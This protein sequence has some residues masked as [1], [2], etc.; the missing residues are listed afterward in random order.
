[1]FVGNPSGGKLL[2]PL[3]SVVGYEG[4]VMTRLR[5]RFPGMIA[6]PGLI[7]TLAAGLAHAQTGDPLA[8]EGYAEPPREIRDAVLAPWHQNVSVG[9]L[10][11]DRQRFIIQEREGMPPISLLA[12]PHV[13]L[14]GVPVDLN[15]YRH[16][17]FTIR[18]AG[19]FRIHQLADGKQIS[20]TAPG[21]AGVSDPTWSPDGSRIAF[22]GHY[23]EGTYLYVADAQT[24]RTK[25]VSARPVLA[26]LS[27]NFE[28]VQGGKA[29]VAVL[30]PEGAGTR[31]ALGDAPNGPLVRVTDA[32]PKR[33]RTHASLLQ[34]PHDQD[35]L[36]YFSTGQ[37][38]VVDV[39]RGRVQ[40]IGKPAMVS[41][42]SSSPD[43]RFFRVTVKERPFSYLVP[44]GSFPERE[45]IWDA[46]GEQKAQIAS[47]GLRLGIVSDPAPVDAW[48][49]FGHLRPSADRWPTDTPTEQDA[50]DAAR[51]PEVQAQE[52]R[53]AQ[54]AAP[55]RSLSWRPDGAGLSFLQLE[56]ARQGSDSRRKDRV[57]LWKGPYGENDVEVVYE[58]EEG[59][60]NLRYSED[61]KTLFINQA[62]GTNRERI[63]MVRLSEPA[64]PVTLIEWST[65]DTLN[66]TGDLVTKPSDVIGS[67]VRMSSDGRYVYLSGTRAF[68]DPEKD[69]PR[70]FLDRLAIG[71]GKPERIFESSED[72]FETATMLDD[73]AQTLLV[74]RQSPTA[75][76]NAFLMDRS[77]KTEVQITQNQ[78]FIPDLTQARKESL[79]VTR[80]DGI[81]FRVRVTLPPTFHNNAR[82]PALFWFYP[83]EYTDQAA[84]NRTLRSHNKNLFTGVGPTSK[85]IFLRHGYVLVEPDCP[86]IGP[87][88]RKNDG[89][90]PQLRNNL[91]AVIDALDRAGY[92]DRDRLALGGHS[93]G[94]FSTANAM[95]HTPFFRAGIAGAGNYNR[96]LTPFGFQSET[97]Q[98]WES[99]EVYLGMSPMLHL[100]QLTGALLLYHG[101]Q[102]QNMGT[103]PTN[104]ERLYQALEGLG[105]PASLYMYPYED[106]GQVARETVLDMWARWI[107]WMEQYVKNPKQAESKPAERDGD[108][109]GR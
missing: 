75:I 27:T 71:S 35:L 78:D 28:W 91:Y 80:P 32:K 38:A 54:A 90:I 82:M 57:M 88:D 49:E 2:L 93:Y 44:I 12:R 11:R 55:R 74:N 95:V 41:S 15:A 107:A 69:A 83:R 89:Y 3:Q 85:T 36:E 106:H 73:D 18:S 72:R 24:G 34:S 97:R 52:P 16:R 29:L 92:I 79:M 76:G 10:S 58:S 66:P 13:I 42:F 59:I 105:K 33:L 104:S 8:G 22:F 103:S 65:T 62:A 68:R 77:R 43:G 50:Q 26:T 109:G 25:R 19:G 60:R 20:I 87:A 63:I 37:L 100:E 86:I 56:P 102:D 67:V 21:N 17:R 96:L 39:E 98:L 99:R 61:C 14:A 40:T 5:S 53:S 70:P 31:P 30:V 23:P 45:V 81:R 46:N 47:R 1:M 101:A 9:N 4:G 84:Y 94:A 6:C 51:T 64:K 48:D 7:V 108:G